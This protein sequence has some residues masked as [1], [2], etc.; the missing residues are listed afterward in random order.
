MPFNSTTLDSIITAR[1][2]TPKEAA[3]AAAMS[4]KKLQ[5]TL[6]GDNV[7]STIQILK[8][9]NRLAVPAYAFF[10]SSYEI[11]PSEII[12][13]R[14]AKP[15]SLKYGKD[16]SRFSSLFATRDFLADLYKRLG[17][18]APQYLYQIDAEENP[19]QFA[20]SVAKMLDIETL[21]SSTDSKSQFYKMLR[22]SIEDLGIYVIQDHNFSDKIDGFAIYHT[23]FTSN[24]IFV[25]SAKRNHGARTF[26]LAHELAHIFGK[27]SALT[28]NYEFDNDVEKFCNEFASALLIPRD[29]LIKE[30][31]TNRYSFKDYEWTV[32]SADK[33]SEHFKTSIS[34]M[35]VRLAKLGYAKWEY[36]KEFS[37][38]FGSKSY[39]D[40]VKPQSFGGRNG[41]APG[42]VDLAYLGTRAVSVITSALAAGLTSSYEIFEQTGLSK[43]R[44]EGLTAVAREKE[45]VRGVSN[46]VAS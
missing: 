44:I 24:L 14:A 29:R 36:Q 6:Q 22:N 16:T 25:N 7:P 41:P 45:L 1:G 10:L 32:R 17:W 8:L 21:R 18:D 26:T 13:F 12:D 40:S 37:K 31:E 38:G 4:P 46:V 43:K 35:L 15:H 42:V 39:A 20:A 5:E 19:E 11:A 28:N 27:R 30:I 23:S 33:L 3:A 34:A 9:A 2:L